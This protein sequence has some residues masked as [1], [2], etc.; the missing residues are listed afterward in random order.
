MKGRE[1]LHKDNNFKNLDFI[2]GMILA[3]VTHR[4]EVGRRTSLFNLC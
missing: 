1:T 3:A 2:S 4:I